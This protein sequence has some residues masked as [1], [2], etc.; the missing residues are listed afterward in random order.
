[1]QISILSIERYGGYYSGTDGGPA[2]ASGVTGCALS[3]NPDA[4]LVSF[5]AKS[6]LMAYESHRAMFEAYNGQKYTST[7][8]FVICND[9]GFMN[10]LHIR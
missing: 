9:T 5:L 7:G 8:E 2:G 3:S 4:G 6:Q 10:G 1:M